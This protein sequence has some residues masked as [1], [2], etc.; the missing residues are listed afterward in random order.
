MI[1]WTRG[2]LST[3]PSG[4]VSAI[5]PLYDMACNAITT[6]GRSVCGPVAAD[7]G[8]AAGSTGA[9]VGAPE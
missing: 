5:N 1:T 3:L 2:H 7:D 6:S 9:G 8:R 4:I